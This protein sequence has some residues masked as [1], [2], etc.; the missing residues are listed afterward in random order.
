MDSLTHLF[1][2]ATICAA[3][4]PA[5]HRRAAL[6]AGAAL[7]TLPDLDVLP[8]LLLDDPVLRMTW[9]RGPT[10]SLLVL[11]F[12]ALVLWWW[13]RRRGG[14]VAES[15]TRWCLAILVTLLAHPLLDA[16]TV[17]GTQLWWPLTSPPA[18]WSSLFIIDPLFSL[19]WIVA[20]V[21]AWFI[22][23]DV[24]AQ[25][26]LFAGLVLGVVYLGWSQLAK[27]QVEQAVTATLRDTS[28]AAAPRFSVPSPLNTLLWRVVVM[29]PDGYLDGQRSL[30]ADSGPIRFRQHHD[31]RAALAEV[32]GFSRVERLLWFNH[33]FV[34]A[35]ATDRGLLLSDLRM[36]SEPDYVFRFV[37]ARRDGGQWQPLVPTRREPS[38]LGRTQTLGAVWRRIWTQPNE[39]EDGASD[40][41][42]ADRLGSTPA[43][44]ASK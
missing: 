37:V 5:K 16:F 43:A 12:V 11:P 10:H 3:I 4:A 42:A 25:R 1:Y 9:H 6:L 17:Y 26:W 33:H 22:R 20:A 30:M 36:G 15:P 41:A 40:Q 18:M 28:L 39:M 34:R 8:L 2:G 27:R 35:D 24:S 23:R 32:E 31:D 7:N 19:P 29:T 38:L 21:A 14:R 44:S 13:F